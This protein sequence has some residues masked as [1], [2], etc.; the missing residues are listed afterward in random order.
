[1]GFSHSNMLRQDLD[2]VGTDTQVATKTLTDETSGYGQA[3]TG[4]TGSS[5]SIVLGAD[6]S[7][8]DIT[9]L[10]GMTAQSIGR[11]LSLSGAASGGNNGTFLIIRHNSSSSVAIQNLLAVT[12]DT[13]NG[14]VSWVERE[15]YTLQ[16]D[17][18]FVR[19]DR[20]AIKGVAYDQ[21]IPTYVRP[22][23]LSTTVPANL[24]NIAGKTTDAKALTTTR[25]M[26]GNTVAATNTFITVTNIGN[27]Q[28]ATALNRIGIPI[29][30]G[31]DSSSPEATYV[32]LIDPTTEASL[33]VLGGGDVGKRIYGR[34]RAGAATSPDSVEI[35]FRAV[36]KGAALT[37]S[38]AYAWEAGHP[39]TIDAYYGY[40]QRMDQ[41][42]DAVLRRTMVS[43]IQG[44]ADLQHDIVEIRDTIGILDNQTNLSTHLSNTGNFFAFVNL[45]DATPSVVEALNILNSQ[46]G[47]RDYGGPYL[48][49][50][51]TVTASLQTLSDAL[52]AAAIVRT[53]ERLTVDEDANVSHLL[54]GGISYTVDV[55]GNGRN[56]YVFW[57]GI[58]RDPGT[59]ANGDDYTE[60]DSTHITAFTK[61]KA[62][63]HVSYFILT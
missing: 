24:Q 2:V 5:A 45:P 57:R 52:A 50:G 46:I 3:I 47:N 8:P 41:L 18:N 19:T 35:E 23:D 43:G 54:P 40:R 49:D 61:L 32:E 10:T 28:H 15:Q 48:T 20:A 62:G 1:M 44:D 9:G 4:Q 29:H 30:D 22:T 37:S 60:T 42:D 58:L 11:Y 26:L 53:I 55:S 51:Q 33:E 21:P 13:N 38:V 25:A 39:T 12:P 31:A 59:L 27:M 7:E 56:M 63:D 14:M 17:L 34:T 36:T 6:P 16:D